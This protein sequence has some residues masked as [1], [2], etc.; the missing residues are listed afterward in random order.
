LKGSSEP[1]SAPSPLVINGLVELAVGVLTGWIYGATKATPETMRSLGIHSPDR[2]RQWHLELMM[3]GAYTVAC[4]LAVPR[5]PRLIAILLAIG[6]WSSPSAFLPLAFTPELEVRPAF[7]TAAVVAN[8]ATSI[9]FVGM[10]AVGCRRRRQQRR[11]YA[12]TRSPQ[13]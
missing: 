12:L 5:A 13:L 11:E 6:A 7:R 10:A 9:G 1:G 3:Q 2:I 8:L 4:G